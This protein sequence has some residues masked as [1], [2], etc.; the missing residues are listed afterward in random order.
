[1]QATRTT[2]VLG[3]LGILVIMPWL[4]AA[5]AAAPAA[6]PVPFFVTHGARAGTASS[7]NWGGYAVPAARG[8]V[9]NVTGSWLQPT[10]TC[11]SGKTGFASFWVGIDGYNSGSVEQ[12]G[13]DSDCSGSTPTYYAW[14]EFYPHPSHTISGLA[15]HPGDTI[16]AQ[17]LFLGA[18]KFKV[19]ISDVTTGGSFS[20]T[21]SVRKAARSSAEWIAEAP[22]SITGILP[23]AN[24]G[25]VS[26]GFDS[27]AVA[28]TDRATIGGTSGDLGTFTAAVAI[29]MV[30]Q[31]NSSTVKAQP[32]AISTDG[33]SFSVAW[34]NAGP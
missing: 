23:L 30:S 5:G 10:A 31:A 17:V 21:A 18:G 7:T 22:S 4:I 20:T 28:G 27:T 29:T 14:Y 15:I 34:K 1:M 3:A 6:T 24:F 19:S 8:S 25:T 11:T 26:F 32:S 16:S 13:T 9:T 2:F 33:T 12:T